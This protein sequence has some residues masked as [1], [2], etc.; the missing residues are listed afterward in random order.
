MK[1][2]ITGA[3]GMLGRAWRELL[4][5][6]NIEF[7]ARDRASLDLAVPA[8]VDT[9]SADTDVVVN[10]A[11]YTAVDRA[12]E[13]EARATEINGAAVG[14]LLA[15]CDAIGARLVHYSTDYIFDGEANAPYRL[16]HPTN[17]VNAYGR[18]KLA[19][20]QHFFR[21]LAASPGAQHLL[22][23]TSWV[24]APWG[25]NFVRTIARLAGERDALSVVDDQRGRPTSAEH[26]AAVSL[27]LLE[28]DAR[29]VFHVTDGGDCTW[30][31]FATAIAAEVAPDACTVSPCGSDAF[32]RPAPRPAYSVLDLSATEALVGPMTSWRSNLADV[33][34]RRE[35]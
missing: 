18:S 24:Y 20:E 17:P 29:G 3:G 21:A 27:A 22:L 5:A 28:S 1:V 26:L 35:P 7:D 11:A 10:C 16:D 6:R 13:E 32:P 9:I 14:R 33:L 34:A 31:D 30:F 25:Q 4:A 8:A 12:E 19:G 15:R 2:L 23:R